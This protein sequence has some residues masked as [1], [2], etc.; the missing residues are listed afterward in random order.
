[1]N[2][3]L[4][5]GYQAATRDRVIVF[6]RLPAPGQVKTRLIP[7]IGPLRSAHLQRA[8]TERLLRRLTPMVDEHTALEV[9][10]PDRLREIGRWLG[11]AGRLRAQGE[12]DLG[13]RM[14]RALHAAL[15]EGCSHA[16]LV[17]TD[18]P[19]I[20]AGLVG[21]GLRALGDSDVVLGPVTDGGYW[22]IGLS[23]AAEVF[24]GV[25]WSTPR[26]FEQTL[27]SA[28][29]QGL[30]VHTLPALADVDE[31]DD[32]SA[33]PDSLAS[34]ARRP[35]ISVV[36]PAL[37]EA[38]CIAGVLDRVR[39]P[40]VEV[41]VADG[42][43]SD[44]T[45]DLARQNG[46]A[47]VRAARGRS[48]QINAALPH[49]RGEIVLLLHADTLLPEHWAGKVLTAMLDPAVAG[50][51]FRFHSDSH[52]RGMTW[53]DRLIHLRS[54]TLQMPYGDQAIFTRRST[55]MDL[56]GLDDTPLGEDWRLVRELVGRGRLTVLPAAVTTSGRRWDR[57]GVCLT[58]W[59]NQ[60]VV[61]G[62]IFQLP[63]QWL[64]WLYRTP[65]RAADPSNPPRPS[66]GRQS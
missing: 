54:Q 46:A 37:N 24:S 36:V 17:G 34:M 16:V 18:V 29:R 55:L 21:E 48:R 56:G 58:T 41:I 40:G 12:G 14:Q 43:S 20:T 15:R 49:V 63:S 32:L 33:L 52:R 65:A 13:T 1:M 64:R 5:K 61:L 35:A 28:R 6:T 45:P 3:H 30:R 59:I 27:E 19:G 66:T 38:G 11:P 23:T 4:I 50:G 22:L 2:P 39:Q 7:A 10:A 9:R 47:V 26:V 62:L 57:L 42:G 44:G 8:M 31:P 51:A 53:I 60:L 25:E